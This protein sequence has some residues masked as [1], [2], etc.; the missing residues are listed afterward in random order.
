MIIAE[1]FAYS[2]SAVFLVTFPWIVSHS[3]GSSID[4]RIKFHQ[5]TFISMYREPR[6]KLGAI[7][8]NEII[9][10][11]QD[12]FAILLYVYFVSNEMTYTVTKL[13]CPC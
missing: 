13:C 2:R 8:L 11:F 12:S 5:Q 9:E 6:V 7:E 3:Q 4:I 1:M 10:N